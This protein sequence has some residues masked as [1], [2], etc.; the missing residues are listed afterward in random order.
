MF[1][2]LNWLDDEDVQFEKTCTKGLLTTEEIE[3]LRFSESLSQLERATI[4]L[5]DGQQSQK[6]SLAN[7]LPSL[8]V[9]EPSTFSEILP[10]FVDMTNSAPTELLTICGQCV[11]KLILSGR[12]TSHQI[13]SCIVPL[14]WNHINCKEVTAHK[15]WINALVTFIL[16]VPKETLLQSD[17]IKLALEKGNL[18]QKTSSRIACAEIITTLCKRLSQVEAEIFPAIRMLCQDID[19]DVRSAMCSSL[20]DISQSIGELGTVKLLIPEINELLQ[21]EEVQVRNTAITVLI[22]IC[23]HLSKDIISQ[24]LS[25]T[26]WPYL[27]IVICEKPSF[28]LVTVAKIFGR[29]GVHLADVMDEQRKEWYVRYF[30]KLCKPCH[31]L[32]GT[33]ENGVAESAVVDISLDSIEKKESDVRESIAFLCAYNF[34][35]ICLNVGSRL[36]LETGLLDTIASLASHHHY[37]VRRVLAAGIHEISKILGNDSRLL[38]PTYQTLLED[39]NTEVL[40]ALIPNLASALRSFVSPPLKGQS[41]TIGLPDLIPALQT[42]ED[43]ISKTRE[44]RAYT[45]LIEAWSEFTTILTPEQIHQKFAPRLVKLISTNAMLPVKRAVLKTLVKFL[46]TCKYAQQRHELAVQI[47]K[48]L[49]RG[50]KFNQR[51]M[52]VELC[53]LVLDK[54]SKKFFKEYCFT[55]ALLLINDPT[56]IV[57]I[58]SS[59]LLPHLKSQLKMP[60]DRPLLQQLEASSRRSLMSERNKDVLSHIQRAVIELD[61]GDVKLDSEPD[62]DD[63]KR[64][65]E[66]NMFIVREERHDHHVKGRT[67]LPEIG[68]LDI[69]RKPRKSS[70]TS[71]SDTSDNH[72]GPTGRAR[73]KMSHAVMSLSSRRTSNTGSQSATTRRASMPGPQLVDVANKARKSSSVKLKSVHK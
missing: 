63:R 7:S 13:S 49:S 39:S 11:T 64:D 69:N 9:S 16:K 24:M 1:Q 62:P 51:L 18:A 53:Y 66:Q 44:W 12:L 31:I 55:P 28:T 41:P 15:S 6:I 10:Q 72:S 37:S 35:A 45:S 47:V 19:Y 54:F 20:V 26:I 71:L 25:P 56:P 70:L 43:Q 59:T 48:G 67:S 50:K 29:L 38:L 61:Q 17:V 8:M 5:S 68:S 46:H 4:I 52:F 23:P 14:L 32:N 40:I 27:D 22:D 58:K 42:Q 3:D 34:P 73:R 36:V 65:E 30:L 33:V 2:S 57:R 60:S 21:D